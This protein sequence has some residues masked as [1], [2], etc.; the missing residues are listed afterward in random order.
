MRNR[1]KFA[2]YDFVMWAAWYKGRNR[3]VTRTPS[4]LR[5]DIYD[6][7]YSKKYPWLGG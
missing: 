3:N 1:I 5:T 4:K 7:A 2:F 6:W